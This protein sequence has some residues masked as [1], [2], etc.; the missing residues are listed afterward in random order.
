MWASRAHSEFPCPIVKAR[1]DLCRS[2]GFDGVEFDN[3]DGYT[4]ST[5]FPLIA[6]DR[7]AYNRFLAGEAPRPVA[8]LAAHAAPRLSLS[9]TQS[10]SRQFP[11]T[12]VTRFGDSTP[13][14]T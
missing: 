12:P 11:V 1:L 2:K 6:A 8:R 9:V 10:E 14:T 3:L 5:G 7:L 13:R 4:N